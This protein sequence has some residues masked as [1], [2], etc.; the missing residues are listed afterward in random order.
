MF[1]C[2]QCR[3]QISWLASRCPYCTTYIS[4][5][6]KFTI[7]KYLFVIFAVGLALAVLAGGAYY[8]YSSFT[9]SKANQIAQKRETADG[10]ENTADTTDQHYSRCTSL[11]YNESNTASAIR[12]FEELAARFG[13][14]PVDVDARLAS[15]TALSLAKLYSYTS[16]KA[17]STRWQEKANTFERQFTEYQRAREHRA[18][19][20]QEDPTEAKLIDIKPSFDC[21]KS[22]TMVEKTICQSPA[23]AGLDSGMAKALSRKL[24]TLTGEAKQQAIKDHRKWLMEYSARCNSESGNTAV[25]ECITQSL[26]SYTATLARD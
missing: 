17:L 12:C 23:L 18:E 26:S 19:S 21:S 20:P 6:E 22:Q 13:D 15:E 3:M 5:E 4:W 2:L 7:I 1:R 8:I 9:P 11:P 10:A 25:F 16:D 24:A 14:S